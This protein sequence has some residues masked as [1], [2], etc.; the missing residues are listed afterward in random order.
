MTVVDTNGYE[1]DPRSVWAMGGRGNLQ[2]K[3]ADR[4]RRQTRDETRDEKRLEA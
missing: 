2:K 3:G 4:Y 1:L